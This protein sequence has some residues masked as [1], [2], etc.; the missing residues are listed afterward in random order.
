[1]LIRAALLL[2]SIPL[3]VHGAEGLHR[4]FLS[5]N[6]I[7]VDCREFASARPASS[8]VRLTGC[9]VDYVRAGYRGAEGKVTELFLPLRPA[10]TSPAQPSA[11]VVSTKD[12]AVLALAEDAIN[13]ATR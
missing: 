5:R 13:G 9:E 12:P 10:G 8:W 6:Q 4:A 2:V 1:M 3:L 7:A 11:V